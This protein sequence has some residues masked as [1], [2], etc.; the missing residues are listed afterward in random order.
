MVALNYYS[1]G[2]SLRLLRSTADLDLSLGSVENC[3][4]NVSKALSSL[5]SE[6]ISHS[7]E[8]SSVVATKQGF[9]QYGGFPGCIGAIDGTKIKIRAP[10]VDEDAYVGRH[11]GHF[12]NCQA[13]CDSRLKFVE[14]TVRWPGSVNDAT[15]YDHCAF[16]EEFELFLASKPGD[17]QGW[18]IG[19]SGYSQREGMMIPFL[20]PDCNMKVRYKKSRCVI[21]RAFGTLKSRFRCLCKE[22]GGA[23]MFEPDVA[24]AVI[25]SCMVLHIYC[26][27]R[28]FP[29]EI[30]DHVKESMARESSES[31]SHSPPTTTASLSEKM[32]S[33]RGIIARNNLCASH[34]SSQKKVND[35]Y[36]NCYLYYIQ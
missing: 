25:V 15:I 16:R 17:Y 20:E 36:N 9:L 12:I 32:L 35:L 3:V 27:E 13:I 22:S 28:N 5:S 1:S 10:S 31:N 19:D 34:F 23:L 4:K 2:C 14:A 26:I 8:T 24:Y 29:M 33:S 6:Y 7:W 21:E 30:S 18:L 11:P